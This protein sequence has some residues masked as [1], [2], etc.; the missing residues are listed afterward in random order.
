M[1]QEYLFHLEAFCKYPFEYK[2]EYLIF[3]IDNKKIIF[4][5]NS[6]IG[7]DNHDSEHFERILKLRNVN[8]T[9][10]EEFSNFINFFGENMTKLCT[11]CGKKLEYPSGIITHCLA[12]E[13]AIKS[14]SNVIDDNLV[15]TYAKRDIITLKFLMKVAYTVLHS[16]KANLIFFPFPQDYYR[17][18]KI[19]SREFS[20]D[21]TDPMKDI[22]AL[23]KDIDELVK[24]KEFKFYNILLKAENDRQIVSYLGRKLYNFTRF[25]L[26]TNK[27]DLVSS[28]FQYQVNFKHGTTIVNKIESDN[29]VNLLSIK[30][31]KEIENKFN[32]PNPEYLFHGSPL[33]NWFSILRNGIRNCSGS[34]LMANG[35][36]FGSGVYGADDISTP[37]HY[38]GGGCVGVLQ[39]I[40]GKS[41]WKKSNYVVQ[42]DTVLLLRY[43]LLINPGGNIK[44]LENYFHNVLP[45]E[46]N[47]LLIRSTSKSN[48]RLEKEL[49]KI[50]KHKI[51]KKVCNVDLINSNMF[52]WMVKMKF[53]ESVLE[54]ELEKVKQKYIE[55][56][57]VFPETYPMFPPK[58]QMI[59]PRIISGEGFVNSGGTFCL[60]NLSSNSWAPGAKQ[61]QMH[62]LLLQI[63]S[64]LQEDKLKFEEGKY[65]FAEG[66]EAFIKMRDALG[67]K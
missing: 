26:K 24:D 3:K 33:E 47:T 7:E 67:W 2:N 9:N 40:G 15:I 18:D 64:F 29:K 32:V 20:F 6:M 19:V 46:K 13:C 16:T 4:N 17:S 42:D 60:E 28:P 54:K 48:I 14:D 31:S 21:R 30:Y 50:S 12:E 45:K 25:V 38:A 55:L 65:T 44:N 56:E 22:D 10:A 51:L 27:T 43:I 11:V 58:I 41:Q 62:C 66:E 36:A 59:S 39:I 63:W 49:K 8:V 5:L 52:R 35:S 37:L 1:N 53:K 23:K 57:L 34:K 61:N